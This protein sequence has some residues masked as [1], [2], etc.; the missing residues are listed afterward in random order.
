MHAKVRWSV[1]PIVISCDIFHISFD[2]I[3]KS[4]KSYIINL[5]PNDITLF[6]KSTTFPNKKNNIL[7]RYIKKRILPELLFYCN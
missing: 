4:T 3:S 6:I 2:S 1:L 5:A 7:K